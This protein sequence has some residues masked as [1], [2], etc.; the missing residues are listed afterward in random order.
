MENIT[1]LGKVFDKIDALS[2]DCYDQTIN[3]SEISFKNLD[4]INIGS[5]RHEMRNVAQRSICQ[6]LGIPF[7]Y[8][9]KCPPDIQAENLNFWIRQYENNNTLFFR[10]DGSEVRAIF[11]P[12]YVPVDNFEIMERL[13]SLGYPPETEVQCQLDKEFMSLSIPDGKQAFEIDGDRFKPGISISNSECGLASLSISAFILRL[14]CTNG[15]IS[16]SDVSASYR[17]VST[18]ILAEFPQVINQVSQGLGQQR[19]QF[20]LSMESPV[21][22]TQATLASF[23]RQ[24]GLNKP[25]K[26]A[27]EWAL[28][29]E[30]G[31]TMFSVV[32]TYTRAGQ[33][34]G[35]TAESSHRLQRVGGNILAM[36]N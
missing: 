32:N 33:F 1:T 36:L 6:R 3:V 7:Q 30:M 24:F 15:L 5:D 9:Q 35:L 8:L 4:M 28:P 31:D 27:V 13:D 16:K 23:N 2:S 14:I 25:E 29:F 11:T 20:K 10:F 19:S 26:E 21:T 34:D 17:H 22:D 18:K 12:K